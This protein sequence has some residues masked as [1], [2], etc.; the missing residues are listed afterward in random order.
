MTAGARD[1]LTAND[2]ALVECGDLASGVDVDTRSSAV[3]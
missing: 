2:A 3:C 1:Y